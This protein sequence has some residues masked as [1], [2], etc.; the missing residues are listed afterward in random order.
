[1]LFSYLK[2]AWKVLL[3]RKFFTAISLFGIS[4]TLMILLVVYALIDYAAGAHR[5]ELHTDRLLFI[6]RMQL[7]YRDGG[8]SNSGV[9]YAFLDQHARTLRTPEKVSISE[10][11]WGAAVAYV[12]QQVLKLDRK[13]TDAAFWQVLDF[14]FLE[15]RPYNQREVQQEAHVAVISAT[16]ARRYFGSAAG[17]A[18]R[19]IVLDA[20]PYRVVGVV[21]DVA[22]VRL[23][24][25]AEVW[26]PIS[27]TAN[28][29]RDPDYLGQ[30]QAIMLARRPADVPL[31]KDEYLQ[32]VNRVPLPDPKRYS[33]VNSRAQTLLASSLGS[34]EN[35]TEV[36]GAAGHFLRLVG[37]MGLL[38][39]LLPALNLININVSRTLERSSEIGVRKA[40]GATAGRLVGQFLIENIILTLCGAGLGL[41]LA[42]GLL[43][44]LNSSHL[45]PYATFGLN[46]RVF[47]AALGVA[48][49]FGI[50]SGAYPAYKMSKLHAVK[51][52]KGD[53]TA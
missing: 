21:R 32:A 35:A 6:N 49:F 53:L 1:M 26:L 46:G 36:E 13:R 4:F 2:I 24:T 22:L 3:R 34:N 25:Y 15:G 14:D 18:G 45:V 31:I 8:N 20:V 52:L 42:A 17:V 5:P 44:L 12:G 33:K 10:N 48:L 39:L 27:A 7:M 16:T 11:N 23:H 40:F 19:E 30:Y 37:G 9:G 38:F 29:L 51:A 41:G 47:V 28:N 43:A 50:L